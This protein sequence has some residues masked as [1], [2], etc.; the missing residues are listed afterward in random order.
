MTQRIGEVFSYGSY[1]FTREI[2]VNNGDVFADIYFEVADGK[3]KVVVP[4]HKV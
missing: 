4:S 3:K 2:A 1:P